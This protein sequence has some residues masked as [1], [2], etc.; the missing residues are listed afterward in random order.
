MITGCPA[1]D[2]AAAIGQTGCIQAQY[3]PFAAPGRF[4]PCPKSNR[5]TTTETITPV[6]SATSPA[7]MAWR[8]RRTAT[9]PKYTATTEKVVSVLP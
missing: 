7:A 9:A 5:Q 6:R 3:A 4:Y 1:F 2:N 8:V